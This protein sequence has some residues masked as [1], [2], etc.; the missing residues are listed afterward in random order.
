MDPDGAADAAVDD[1]GRRFRA[2]RCKESNLLHMVGD[3][4]A[5]WLAF[6]CSINL[7]LFFSGLFLV[8]EKYVNKSR[9]G[10][11][12]LRVIVPRLFGTD[13][14]TCSPAQEISFSFYFF[15]NIIFLCGLLLHSSTLLKFVNTCNDNQ[16][17]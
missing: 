8:M 11:A 9:G 1:E 13:G 7:F 16:S 5:N 12:P 6:L 10:P 17:F 3:S 4:P 2:L 14:S 15:F